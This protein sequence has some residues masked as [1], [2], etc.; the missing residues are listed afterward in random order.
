MEQTDTIAAIATPPGQ[1]GIGII[2]I[3]G[4]GSVDIARQITGVDP[5]PRQLQF[6]SFPDSAGR[7]IDNG[8][9]L[10]FQ[11]PASYTGEEVIELQGHGGPVVLTMLLQRVIQCGAR[12]ARP[13][14]FT[15]R[16]FL[17]GKLDLAQAEAVA[18]LISSRSEQAARNAFSTLEGVFSGLVDELQHKLI[19]ARVYVE[20]LL[21]FP[22]EEVATYVATELAQRLD[23]CQ[24]AT[25]T[26]LRQS[27]NSRL[28]TQGL[29][30]AII[31]RPNSGKSTLLN[32]LCGSE[33]AIVTEQPGT[34][35]DTLEEEILIHDIP[36]RL[37]DTAGIRAG[38]DAI[39]TEGISRAVTAAQQADII[40]LVIDL[41]AEPVADT[42]LEEKIDNDDN[43]LIRVHN[44]ID[45]LDI[46]PRGDE[47]E[48][49][50][51]AQT[52]AGLDLLR[53]T[54]VTRVSDGQETDTRFAAQQRHISVLQQL[55]QQ[56]QTAR[57]RFEQNKA[58]ELLAADL[59]QMQQ[60]LGT[61]NGEFA[62]D[63]LLGE[64][65]SRFCI[66]K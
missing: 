36:F 35:R 14:E 26:L 64:I 45:L 46:Q 53:Q 33:R 32:R 16:A 4:P 61:I 29:Q 38:S 3:S 24:T 20:S 27:R 57:Q 63:D 11:R 25:D 60:E 39:E 44:K 48:V 31:G 9:M 56:L 42:M 28:Y 10:Y 21:D 40:L 17:N 47:A 55:E 5:V 1:G 2:R 8:I 52:G 62:A 18:T 34:T 65:F 13:G 43:R 6:C 66:G 51:S 37:I 49:Y 50:I 58:L 19:D 22:E 23:V 30:I 7:I 41:S 15:E 54:I 59:Q 12:Q